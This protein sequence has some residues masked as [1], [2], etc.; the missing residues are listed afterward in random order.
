MDNVQF[1]HTVANYHGKA[2]EGP[3][4]PVTMWTV[5]H[6]AEG[7]KWA[8]VYTLSDSIYLEYKAR[9][10]RLTVRSQESGLPTVGEPLG[11]A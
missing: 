6:I 2:K 8:E 11:G 5:L 3:T 10:G 7:R 1:I 9:Q 4:T